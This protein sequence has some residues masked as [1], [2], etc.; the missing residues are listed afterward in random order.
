M[1]KINIIYWKKKIPNDSEIIY[2][3][4]II[5]T[6][7]LNAKIF[8]TPP[9]ILLWIKNNI[10]KYYYKILSLIEQLS[11]KIE[12]PP[13]EIFKLITNGKIRN[14]QSIIA[15][16]KMVFTKN[17]K[18]LINRLLNWKESVAPLF[19]ILNGITDTYN[20]GACLRSVDAAGAHGII[21]PKTKNAHIN[22]I[23]R[24]VSS[25][26]TEVVLIYI[27]N[28]LYNTINKLRNLGIWILGTTNKAKKFLFD[29]DL[30]IPCAIIMGSE[31]YGLSN[32]IKKNCDYLISLPMLGKIS[33]LN[34]SVA[35]G[36]CLFEAV[37][38]RNF[39][40]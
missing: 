30:K 22:N 6:I 40:I 21:I 19:L 38:Q 1:H 25:G 26:A 28:N 4:H 11:I 32:L 15:F 36:I 20:L 24:K 10:N 23:V 8:G 13:N 33:S 14:N 5:K 39:K 18:T 9:P 31:G 12:N 35:A 27:V 2:N 37:R 17:E 3:I 29:I 34:I 16:C 7:L